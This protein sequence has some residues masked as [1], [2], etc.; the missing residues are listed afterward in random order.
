M[1]DYRELWQSLNIDLQ[2]HDQLCEVLPKVYDE[3]YLSQQKRPEGMNYFNLVVSEIHGLRI[4]ELAE[5][6]KEGGK[7]I[8]SFCVFVPD[9]ISNAAGVINVGLCA[10]SDFWH[11][12]GEKHVP[13]NTCPLVKA[14]VGAKIGNTCPYFNSCDM[15]VGETTCDSKKKAWEIL[16]EYTPMHV[17][18][19]PQMKRE[20]DY[21]SFEDEMDIF[22]SK[23]EELSGNEVTYEK[24]QESIKLINKK[25]QVLQRLYDARKSP[26]LPIS[27]KD[28]LL[29][30]QIA[31]YDDPDRFIDM[32]T[33]LCEELEERIEKKDS[34]FKEGT[35]RIMVSGTPMA[36]PNWKLH[37][38]I[39]SSGGAVVCEETCTGTRYFENEV[40]EDSK[41]QSQQF[42]ALADRYMGINCACFTPNNGRIEDIIRLYKEYGAEGVVYFTLPFCQTYA[43]E[44]K[45]VKEALDKE[46]IP[47][48]MIETGYS[49]EDAGQ[50]KTR[51]EAFF[52]MLDNR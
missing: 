46:G 11:A 40:S 43:T 5:H 28:S 14:A 21:K 47:V 25:R 20:K 34:V 13:N 44:Y 3:V 38:V 7:V 31:F 6:K 51:L 45:K 41:D 33:K 39:E 16:D 49:L 29:V 18:D 8:G 23:M 1:G 22:K 2:K 10:G 37:H 17:I 15:L 30:S 35:K 50:I 12:D 4:Q 32:T 9:E 52:E 42:R 26:Y 19:L 27:G 24:L 48:I 36:I